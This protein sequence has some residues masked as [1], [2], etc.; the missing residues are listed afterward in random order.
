MSLW[1]WLFHRRQREEELDEEVQSHLR[2]AAQE[3]MEQGETAEQARTSA[4]REFGNVTLVKEVTRDMWG[5]R[6][7]E[8]LL[9]DLRYG[10]RQLKRS[11]G[12]T[13]VALIMLALGIG[14]TTTIFTAANDFL[15]R[16]LPFGNSDRLVL[17]K[18]YFKDVPQ[19]GTNDPPTFNFWREKNHVFDDMAAWSVMTDHF[20][21]TGAEGPERVP[22]KQVSAAFFRVLG[23]KPILGRTFSAA[24]DLAG[25]NRVAVISHSLWQTR[26]GGRASILGKTLILDGKDYTVIGVLPAGFR[27]STTPEE[28]WTPLALPLWALTEGHG[29]EFLS[30]IA[31]LKPGVTLAQA[32]AN[33][34]AITT[35]WARQFP[36]W[37]NGDQWVAV[38]TVRD[39]YARDLRPA[40]LVLLVAAALVLLIACANLAN[41]LLARASSR[42][43]EIAMRRALGASRARIIHQMLIESSAL[44]LLGGSAGLLLAFAGTRVFYAALPTG[45]QPL[46]RG[47]IDARV[48]TFAL[49][50]LLLTVFLIGLAPAWSATGFDLNEG[51]KE[52][53][54]SPLASMSRRSFRAALVAGEVA[55]AAM[56]LTGATLVIKSFVRLSAVNL[57]FNSENVLTVDLARTR[58]GVDA[59]YREVIERIAALPQVRAAG[60]IN[61][62][63]LYGGPAW[64]QDI[65]IE[66]R[67]PRAPNDSIYAGH[68]SVSLGYFRAMGIPLLKGRSFAAADQD[69]DVA[70]ISETMARRYWPSED[71][72]GKRFGVNCSNSPCRWNSIIGVVGDVKEDGAT[73]EPATLMYFPEI[74]S[75]M[76]LVVRAAQNPTTLIADVRGIVRSVDPDQPV[77]AV[78]SMENTVSEFVAP[79]RITMLIAGLFATLALFLA[80]VGLYGVLSYSVAQRSHEFGI[81]MA[82][83]AAKGDILR[84]IVAQGFRLV[85]AGIIVGMAGALALTRVLSSLL[86]GITPNDPATFVAVAILLVCVA[87][88]A[89]SIPARRATKV[90]PMVALRY[91]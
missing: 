61:F 12:F 36:D 49:V 54:R 1:D 53:L 31:L 68:R 48:L 64:G 91:E 65:T 84:L 72:I 83:G 55:L 16:P 71:P 34:E 59:F 8:A 90:D 69:K 7:L 10:L 35:P 26:Y 63:P 74:W 17:V 50:T 66:G 79:Q 23:V 80:M 82:L 18:R 52:G 78:H 51:L 24:E 29:G 73:G 3:R 42:Y 60:A 41:L 70:V 19:S 89:C 15:L 86:F 13:A 67:P 77:G 81:R 4:A 45:W 88:L 47:G 22:A 20:N 85:L 57:G 33:V 27:F 37:G 2:M 21:L 39:R 32:Q 28:V 5:F 87:L 30:V 56:L 62:K 9:Q 75:T 25:G 58:K 14:V 44:A 11:P 43:K 6:W 38:E 76:T 40:L 46:A